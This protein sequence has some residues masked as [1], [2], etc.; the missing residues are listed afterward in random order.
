MSNLVSPAAQLRKN[1]VFK[2]LIFGL[3]LFCIAASQIATADSISIPLKGVKKP[4]ADLIDENGV[5]LDVGEAS[6][7]IE[8][9]DDLSLLDPAPNQFWQNNSYPA[10]DESVRFYPSGANGV[11]YA[12][13]EASSAHKYM[14]MFMARVTSREDS[15]KAFRLTLSRSTHSAMM[16][17]ALLRKLGFFLPS[18]KVYR[19]LTVYFNNNEEMEKFLIDAQ[20]ESVNDFDDR[21]WISKKDLTKSSVTFSLAVLE[22]AQAEYVDLHWGFA[23]DPNDPRRLPLIQRYSKYRAFRSLIIP[24]SLVDVPESL[25][26]FSPKAASIMAGQYILTHPFAEA[27]S[28]AAIEDI[29]WILRKMIR[30]SDQDWREIVRAGGWPAELEEL[31]YAKLVLRAANLLE[32]AGMGKSFKINLPDLGKINSAKG[33]V[34]EGKITQERVDGYPLRYAH[35]E[36][37]SPFNDGDLYRYFK[38]SG[39]SSVIGSALGM[40]N[41]KMQVLTVEDA[42]ADR[43]QTLKDRIINHIKTKPLEPLYQKIEAWGGPLLGVNVKASRNLSTGTF[44]QSTAAVQLVD[45]LQLAVNLGY[46]LT[47]EGIPKIMPGAG[48]NISLIR[49][50]THVQPINTIEEGSKIDWSRIFIPKFMNGLAQ[51]LLNCDSKVKENDVEVCQVKND[52]GSTDHPVDKFVK[53][54]RAGEV[55]TVTDTVALSTYL[56][57]SSAL[58]VLM[59]IQP[60]SFL[61]SVALGVDGSRVILSQTSIMKTKEGLQIYVRKQ[62]GNIFGL[63]LDVN[64]FINLLR[65]RAQNT[66]QT[67][68]TNAFVID[69]D[70]DYNSFLDKTSKEFKKTADVRDRLQ[71]V[72]VP[73]IKD[74]NSELLFGKF[75]DRNIKVGH[76]LNTDSLDVKFLLWKAS[77][78]SEGHTLS[79]TPPASAAKPDLNP[80]D[81]SVIIQ[82]YRKGQLVGR[83][84]LGLIFDGIDGVFNKNSIDAQISRSSNPNPANTLFGRAFWRIAN[85]QRDISKK[86]NPYQ[87]SATIQHVW[88]GW[89][90][91]R[92]DFFDITDKIEKEMSD[93]G[94]VPYRLVEKEA[95]NSVRSIDF[96]RI[97]K[98]L[99]LVES[100]IYKIKDLIMQPASDGKPTQKAMFLSR[101]FQKLS[102]AGGS[103][104]AND[105]DLYDELI[106]IIGSGDVSKGTS[107]YN[108]ACKEYY[109]RNN[110]SSAQDNYT[111]AWVYGTYYDCIIPWTTQ[112]I[113]LGRSW[114]ANDKKAQAQWATEVLY[115]LDQ[116]IPM[117]EL[118]KY[119]GEENYVFFVRVNGFR[120]GDEDG[121]TEYFGNAP[122]S[123]P[124]KFEYSNGLISYWATKTKVSPVELDRTNGAFQ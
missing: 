70:P 12:Y 56:Q 68:D 22:P 92:S 59:G 93:S 80:E 42:Q 85:V 109:K 82:S 9:G 27:F 119:L 67:I 64:Y 34:K 60:L 47:L 4:A 124:A 58:D 62:K 40:I 7:R 116:Y 77:Q 16:R 49:D 86:Q 78:F 71:M 14:S 23:P 50:F 81:E 66:T 103:A 26:R 72:L 89:S 120:A 88:G 41:K 5:N 13:N 8:K 94:M 54:L 43:L 44:Y 74:N 83:D 53:T 117:A 90:I 84:L 96:Y 118:L 55:I 38:I 102:Q 6:K 18:P 113:A 11:K 87:W 35:G 76:E 39:L 105:K 69:Y 111:G 2:S 29:R 114:P 51:I 97:T 95:F 106:K 19:D 121:D 45:N 63:Q 15:T 101:F 33:L 25:E 3:F 107:K 37:T 52:D 20:K 100:G 110:D 108:Q 46:F 91:S 73:L 1:T 48:A 104:R 21:K 98:Q 17:A 75:G 123:P 122:G 36:R 30:L 61:N 10:T 112:L 31:A 65:V 79:I 28:S 57:T 115:V 32:L 24:F 99:S